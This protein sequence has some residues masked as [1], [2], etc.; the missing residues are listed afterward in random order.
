MKPLVRTA[1]KS[2]SG[3][4]G[5]KDLDAVDPDSQTLPIQTPFWATCR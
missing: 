3:D 4:P 2:L 1:G 5:R